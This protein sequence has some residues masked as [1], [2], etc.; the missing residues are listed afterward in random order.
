[1]FRATSKTSLPEAPSPITPA[2]VMQQVP[3]HKPISPMSARRQKPRRSRQTERSRNYKER[4]S[5][6]FLLSLHPLH[7]HL[8]LTPPSV[9]SSHKYTS[10][11]PCKPPPLSANANPSKSIPPSPISPSP[12]RSDTPL[13]GLGTVHI[14]PIPASA[15]RNFHPPAVFPYQSSSNYKTSPARMP[16]PP[17]SSLST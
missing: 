3:W 12:Y 7:R 13:S 6:N 2:P 5:R 1:V 14:K 11:K 17:L 9:A 4:R 10:E 16:N 15:Q 8:L